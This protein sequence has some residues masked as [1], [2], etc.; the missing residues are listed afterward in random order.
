M[1]RTPWLRP[2]LWPNLALQ[3]LTTRPPDKAMIE[4]AIAAFKA[5]HAADQGDDPITQKQ[6]RATHP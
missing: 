1:A 4:V 3:R 5:M 6:A 2:L